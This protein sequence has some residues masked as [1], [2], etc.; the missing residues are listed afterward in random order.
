MPCTHILLLYAM[1]L[2]AMEDERFASRPAPCCI[3]AEPIDADS[4]VEKTVATESYY[5]AKTLWH[6]INPY[7]T[8]S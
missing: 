1:V 7:K 6:G 3:R 4:A 8:S 2:R 5:V